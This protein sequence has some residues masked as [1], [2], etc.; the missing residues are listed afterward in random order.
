LA[1]DPVVDEVSFEERYERNIKKSRINGVYIPK[2]LEE[3]MTELVALSTEEAIAKFKAGEEELVAR[4]LHFG[5]GRWM[6]YNWNF[7]E[8]SR[9]SHYLKEKGINHPDDQ[10]RFVI[11]S[12]HRKLNNKDIDEEG[13]VLAFQMAREKERLQKIKIVKEET[14]IREID[15]R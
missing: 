10:A 15:H 14:R 1:Q 4:R 2:D 8:G 11:V 3:A 12:L 13:Q 6:I 9:F 5:L 7:Y